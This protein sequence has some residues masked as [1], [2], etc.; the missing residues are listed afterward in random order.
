MDLV[1]EQPTRSI[2]AESSRE[3]ASDRAGEGTPTPMRF[4]EALRGFQQ[5]AALKTAVD[6]DLFTAIADGA[7][8]V[9]AIAGRCTAS[10]RGVRI[11]CDYL[12]ATGFL[13][14]EDGRYG[15]PYDSFVFLNRH[16]PAYAGSIANFICSPDSLDVMRNLTDVV[17]EGTNRT[18]RALEPENPMWVVF[19]RSM[20]PIAALT[21]PL[22]ADVLKV[23][24]AG[25]IRVLDIA[26]GHGLYG[27]TV[28]QQSPQAEIVAVDWAPVLQ[29]AKENAA[30]AGVTSRYATI[31][32]DAMTAALGNDY[33]LVLLTN[34]LHHFDATTIVAF[35]EKVRGTLR[36]GG[37]AAALE[38][39]LDEDRLT[40]QGAAWFPL[41]MLAMTPAGDAYTFGQYRQM[42]GEA[43]FRD[44]ELHDIPP[45]P[46]RVIVAKK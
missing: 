2:P 18:A 43:G 6:L 19:A 26:A 14:K 45:S 27:V 1:S 38:F 29:V 13:T 39:V 42:F 10:A 8:T 33:D 17:R 9:E 28:A 44:V 46:Q 35:L 4:F 15:L 11:L 24:T 31:A 23:D 34:F 20:A 37:R 30:A 16:S 40:P 41:T 36:E 5:S 25:R 21:A 7:Q 12:A 3:R 22:V 32:G